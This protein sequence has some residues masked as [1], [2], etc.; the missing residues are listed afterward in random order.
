MSEP[1]LPPFDEIVD[2]D[3]PERARLEAVHELLVAAGPPPELPPAL[4][5]APP[6]PKAHT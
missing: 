1:R 2:P 5:H 3:D 4:E 6:E